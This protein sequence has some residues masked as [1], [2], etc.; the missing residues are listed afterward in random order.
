M[1]KSKQRSERWRPEPG[2]QRGRAQAARP[3]QWQATDTTIR[4][5]Q[6]FVDRL[7]VNPS[8]NNLGVARRSYDPRPPRRPEDTSPYPRSNRREQSS[9][10]EEGIN[11]AVSLP[12]KQGPSQD[13]CGQRRQPPD[14]SGHFQ[15]PGKDFHV[16]CRTT[17]GHPRAIALGPSRP[18]LSE[19]V[20]VAVPQPFYSLGSWGLTL[21][22]PGAL[23]SPSTTAAAIVNTPAHRP[24]GEG[25]SFPCPDG[26]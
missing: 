19:A 17:P 11:A 2:T 15:A 23:G 21:G 10:V 26:A 25:P 22:A 12:E 18:V 9:E 7:V 8:G 24:V 1:R 4:W 16:H 13:A 5:R 14:S 6:P 20:A 3:T